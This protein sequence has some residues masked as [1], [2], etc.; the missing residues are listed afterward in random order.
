M[1]A[2]RLPLLALVVGLV[3]AASAV[4]AALA[5]GGA[6]GGGADGGDGVA[7]GGGADGGDVAVADATAAEVLATLPV[8]GS[9]PGTGYDRVGDFGES[10]LDVDGNGCGTR[11]D[12]LRRD[13]ADAVTDDGCVVRAGELDDPYTGRTIAF[14]RG[15][16]TSHLVQIDHVVALKDA[17][18]TGAQRLSAQRRVAL[19][20]DPLN[21]LAV[22]G[23]TNAQ[24]GAGNAATWLPPD[25]AFR[26]AYVARQI[27]VK[28]AYGLWVVPAEKDAMA[29]VLDACP[30]EPALA[31]SAAPPSTAPGPSAPA[32]TG[33][34][35]PYESCA[36]ARADG[37]APVRRGDA[38]YGAH[39]DRDGDGV[40]CE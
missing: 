5:G 33:P 31:A 20:N 12:I 19:A 18:R 14:E 26:C 34:S 1:S 8:K 16:D 40:A 24:K 21:L 35:A 9:A 4:L 2:R 37:A 23:S 13:L 39:L 22:D 7:D 6:D 3:L 25:K 36:A 30:D 29:R 27:S 11:D 10:W 28:A 17:W 32:V 38:G 15:V